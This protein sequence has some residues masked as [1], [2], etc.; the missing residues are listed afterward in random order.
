[1]NKA[2]LR[3]E[4]KKAT[5]RVTEIE[6]AI[7]AIDAA[8]ENNVFSSLEEAGQVLAE[9]LHDE[10]LEDCEGAGNCGA[11]AYLQEFIVDGVHYIGTLSVE[12]GR[13]DKTYYYIDD[14]DW[15]VKPKEWR[16]E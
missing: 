6:S 5:Q 4:L 14:I 11:D 1:M 2:E 8:P 9:R 7:F 12:Y 13:H 3:E 10:A 16:E 15:S